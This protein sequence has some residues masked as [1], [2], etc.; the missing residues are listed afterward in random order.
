[1]SFIF[2]Q[3][4]YCLYLK[5][6]DI[7]DSSPLNVLMK[8]IIP[9]VW[10]TK[11]FFFLFFGFILFTIIGT[12]THECG[13]YLASRFLGFKGGKIGYAYTEI[14]ENDY[15][16][17]YRKAIKQYGV[18]IANHSDFPG[19]KQFETDKDKSQRDWLLVGIAG[20]LE[21]IL[22]GS[23][24]LIILIVYRNKF[25]NSDSLSPIQWMSILVTLFWLR[26]SFNLMTWLCTFLLTGKKLIR[27]DE[28]FISMNLGLGPLTISI[29]SA[30]SG[31]LVLLYVLFRIIPVRQRL[32]F[33]CAG[34]TGGIAGALLWLVF[35][36]PKIMPWSCLSRC[37][38]NAIWMK[39]LH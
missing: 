32:T 11:S 5:C 26:G 36:G 30:I 13:H 29:L 10:N 25:L 14:G 24:G 27:S 21:T 12:L 19:M 1:M 18:E 6:C 20:P 7:K 39:T 17:A 23:I 8:K 9:F 16:T 22:T 31:I 2:V 34:F 33:L 38:T 4:Y 3:I 35:L 15:T 37:I 28:F